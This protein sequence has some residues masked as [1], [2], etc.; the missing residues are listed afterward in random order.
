MSNFGFE[1]YSLPIL[2]PKSYGFS[3]SIIAVVFKL[4]SFLSQ[5]DLYFFGHGQDYKV[6]HPLS[7]LCL[8]MSVD[9]TFILF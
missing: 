9:H 6:I 7:I 1:A 3:H 4:L 2:V 5:V 8:Y